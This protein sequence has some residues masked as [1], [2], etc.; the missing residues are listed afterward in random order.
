MSVFDHYPQTTAL[1]VIEPNAAEFNQIDTKAQ[2][3]EEFNIPSYL[4]TPMGFLLIV[5]YPSA[6]RKAIVREIFPPT[7]PL[8]IINLF[9]QSSFRRTVIFRFPILK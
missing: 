6:I 3:L 9:F 4:F 8:D 2:K 1:Y 7:S 5:I